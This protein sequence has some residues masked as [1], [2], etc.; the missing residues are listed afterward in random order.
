MK[1][2][3]GHCLLTLVEK[4][5]RECSS[6]GLLYELS[7]KTL[8]EEHSFNFNQTESALTLFG[9]CSLEF[10]QSGL[11]FTCNRIIYQIT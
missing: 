6:E 9:I 8:P 5:Y 7:E 2:W 10:P 11:V 1:P 3:K 4:N